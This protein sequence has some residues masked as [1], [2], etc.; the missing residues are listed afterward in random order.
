MELQF[1]I[2]NLIAFIGLTITS[3]QEKQ[4]KFLEA[5]SIGT[6]NQRHAP[7]ILTQQILMH[8]LKIIK[9]KINGQELDLPLTID[10][11]TI[12]YFYQMA[13]TKSTI[14]NT[15]LIV[16]M[17]IPI[18]NTK[19]YD[20]MKLTSFPHALQNNIFNFI[21]PNPEYIAIDTLREKYISLTQI[22]LDNCHHLSPYSSQSDILCLELS[23]IMSTRDDDCTTNLVLQNKY[24]DMCDIRVTKITSETWIKLQT[25]NSYIAIFPEPQ[26]LHIKCQNVPTITR[27]LEGTGIISFDDDCH[28]KTQNVLIQAHRNYSSK[29]YSQLQ[30]IIHFDINF[31]DTIKII[32]SSL[33]DN[34]QK[35]DLPTI[36]TTD[37][38]DKL[39]HLS[40][41]LNVGTRLATS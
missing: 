15:Q 26:T 6:H 19:Q 28:I 38:L 33:S 11:D 23:P 31:N 34:I 24:P 5:L 21:L 8:E 1:Q 32:N 25:V 20:L 10:K 13:D 17:S 7:M 4:R 2:Q 41:S 9:D 35:L 18:M 30:P 36:I 37:Q 39:Q 3:F 12:N 16:V 22:E 40:S 14:V 27:I 29:L